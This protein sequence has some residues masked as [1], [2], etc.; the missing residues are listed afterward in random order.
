MITLLLTLILV[1][2]TMLAM[3]IG[4]MVTGRRLRG[5]CGGPSCHCLAEGSDPAT[6][7]HKDVRPAD[8]PSAA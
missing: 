6:C 8:T 5:S 1:A 3:A 2:I 7:E 4:V